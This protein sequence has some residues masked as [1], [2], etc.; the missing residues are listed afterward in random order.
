MSLYFKLAIRN[1]LRQRTGSLINILG[2]SVSLAAFLVIVLF[3][4]NEIAFDRHHANYSRIYRLLKCYDGERMPNQPMVFF[5]ALQDKVPGLQQGTTVYSYGGESEFVQR[6]RDVFFSGGIVFT[7]PGFFRV[8]TAGW[9]QGNPQQALSAANQVILTESM[10]HRIFGKSNPIGQIIR[11]RNKYNLEVTGVI[12]DFPPTSHFRVEML[13]SSATLKEVSRFM[14]ESWNNSSTSFYYVLPPS[15]DRSRLEQQIRSRYMAEMGVTKMEM[16]F[17]LQ[18]LPEIHLYSAD[19][20]WDMSV[21]GDIRVVKAFAIIAFFILCIACFNYVNLSLALSG[22]SNRFTGIQKTMGAGRR[23]IV[24]STL[25]ES[26]LLVAICTLLA[27]LIT[28]FALPLFNRMMETSLRISD[29]KGGILPALALPAAFAVIVPSVIQSWFRVKV[30]PAVMLTGNLQLWHAAAGR[31]YSRISRILT[32]LQLAVSIALVSGVMVVSRQTSLMLDRQLGF[33]KS[34]LLEIRLP[35]DDHTSRNYG[36]LKEQFTHLPE[37]KDFGASWNSPAE[38]INNYGS[39]EFTGKDGALHQVS[40]GQL[41]VDE[42]YLRVLEARFLSGR[43]MDPRVRADSTRMLINRAGMEALGMGNPVGLKVKN[44]FLGP[45]VPS[46]EIAGVIDNI[47]Y[48]SLQE[49]AQPVCFYLCRTELP[50]LILRMAPGD[51]APALKKL[52]RIWTKVLPDEPF[53][54]SFFEDKLESNYKK[55]IRTKQVLTTMAGIAVFI[56]M[57]G[58]FGLGSFLALR[59]RKEIGIRKVNGAGI[60]SILVLLNRGFVAWVLAALVIATPLSY[61]ALSKWLES[62]AYRVDLSGWIFLLSGLL[63]LF[64]SLFTLSFQSFRVAVANPVESIKYE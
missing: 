53:Q 31:G 36:L 56:S 37:V 49:A 54:Y 47:Q 59:R 13:V 32:V 27:V 45:E 5:Q 42:G 40:F 58:V 15:V 52:E 46:W 12:R 21:R 34:R 48:A 25:T 18:P 19:T 10:A 30:N 55:D 39:L 16:T 14:T 57:L 43:N 3:I 11:Y 4:R 35:W 23:N 33:N 26:L 7:N 29:L 60:L 51:L 44:R 17:Q 28:L 2:L 62:F 24:A 38:N 1:L 63:V 9:L 61:L 41:P 20:R 50:V 64:I 8:F 6:G 22:R